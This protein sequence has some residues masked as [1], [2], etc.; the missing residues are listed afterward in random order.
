[1]S[2][3]SAVFYLQSPNDTDE[4][5][6]FEQLRNP[7]K[8]RQDILLHSLGQIYITICVTTTQAIATSNIIER[9]MLSRY[10]VFLKVRKDRKAINRYL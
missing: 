3:F 10:V 6:S 7:S 9:N 2:D 1:M 8:G 5:D 4:K